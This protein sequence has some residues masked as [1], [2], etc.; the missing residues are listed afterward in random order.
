MPTIDDLSAEARDVAL[1][2]HAA[3][4]QSDDRERIVAA[5]RGVEALSQR[6]RKVCA[7]LGEMEK[8]KVDRT[9]GRRITD[10]KRLV[11]LLP[12]VSG[13]SEGSTPDRQ[14]EGPSVAG[15]R[16]ITGVSWRS[17]PGGPAI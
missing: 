14:V 10:L 16:R 11:S 6:Y 3:Q 15:E 17:H 5:H 7:T 8:M 9:V 1:L 12:R 4:E 13:V 2:V